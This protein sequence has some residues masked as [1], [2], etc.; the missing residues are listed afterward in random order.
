M[1]GNDVFHRDRAGA[2]RGSWSGSRSTARPEGSPYRLRWVSGT[3][4]GTR[5]AGAVMMLTMVPFAVSLAQVGQEM[6]QVQERVRGAAF[7]TPSVAAERLDEEGQVSTTPAVQ[8]LDPSQPLP[9]EGGRAPSAT[10]SPDAVLMNRLMIE[11]DADVVALA[12]LELRLRRAIERR[13]VTPAQ[14]DAIALQLQQDLIAAGYVAAAVSMPADQDLRSGTV[15]LVIRSGRMGK[16]NLYDWAPPE[17]TT[18]QPFSAIHF[19]QEQIEESLSALIEGDYFNYRTFRQA[20]L[21]LNRHPDLKVDADLRVRDVAEDG[22]TA[23]YVDLDLKI[24]ETSPLHVAV[25]VANDGTDITEAWR[26]GLMLQHLNLTGRD[27]VLTLSFPFSL[28]FDTIRSAA[29]SYNLPHDLGRGGS[30]TLYGGYTELEA[31]DILGDGLI[32]SEGSGWFAGLQSA[33]VLSASD[34]GELS[35]APGIAYRVIENDVLLRDENGGDTLGLESDITITPLSLALAYRAEQADRAGGRNF[36]YLEASF[37]PG[38]A[39]GGSG[40]DEFANQRAAAS[41]DYAV[42]RLQ[43][44]RMQAVGAGRWSVYARGNVQYAG[45]ALIPAEQMAIG[46]VDSVR[47]YPERVLL[48]DDGAS[49]TLE[50]RSPALGGLLPG[51][52]DRWQFVAF[53]DAGYARVEGDA[54]N[55]LPEESEEIYSVGLGLRLQLASHTQLRADW[56][57]PLVDDIVSANTDEEI[58]SGGRGH[59]SLQVQF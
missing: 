6:R 37:N 27:D 45:D 5:I 14:L 46:G 9:R 41:P 54:Q 2:A 44:A 42:L 34:Q 59:F 49:A 20:L 38:D 57:F 18:R 7:T 39:L 1:S 4:F 47:G 30:F 48:G 50:L 17:Q 3:C 28:D 8:G 51:G 15:T 40:D 26:G 13:R 58:D 16:I 29:A 31:R 21:K 23:R 55:G 11:G 36:A 35:L 56:G 52:V 32:D 53:A 24:E 22:D 19:S 25:R 33:H 12:G 43:L 10:I